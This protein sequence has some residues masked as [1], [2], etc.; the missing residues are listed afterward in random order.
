LLG[1][2]V[3]RAPGQRD[4]GFASTVTAM[5]LVSPITWDHYLVLLFLPL[6]ILWVQLPRVGMAR[7]LLW[8]AAAVCWLFPSFFWY[9]FMRVDPRT[10]AWLTRVATPGEAITTLSIQFYALLVL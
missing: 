9:L 1:W 10:K 6:A 5:L 3:R 2:A 8:I 7:L 4:L